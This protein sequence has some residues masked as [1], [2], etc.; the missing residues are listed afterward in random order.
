MLMYFWGALRNFISRNMTMR[1]NFTY[2]ELTLNIDG[3]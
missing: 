3:H 1:S 2:T